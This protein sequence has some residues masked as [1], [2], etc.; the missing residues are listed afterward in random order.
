MPAARI[1]PKPL[2]NVPIDD[3]IALL[4]HPEQ[5]P[6][7][8][9]P[10]D[11]ASMVAFDPRADAPTLVH[12]WWLAE[13]AWMSYSHSTAQVQQVYSSRT[14]LSAS[15]EGTGGTDWTIAASDEFAIVA[16]RGTQPDQWEDIFSDV[17]WQPVKWD[18]GRVHLGFAEAFER[19]WPALRDRLSTLRP[20]CRVWFT[21][22]SLGAAIATLAAF[23]AT[24]AQGVVTFG[25]PLVGD[26][27][28]AG[29]F[30]ARFGARSLGYA[31]DHDLVTRVPPEEFGFPGRYTHVDRL[32]WIDPDGNIGGAPPSLARFF[33]ATIGNPVFLL[34]LMNNMETLGF[35]ALPDGLRDHTPLHYVIRVWND[36]VAHTVP[37]I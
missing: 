33:S 31:N 30:N 1:E 34:H 13:A 16:F 9:V 36:L 10:F 12:V 4:I 15:L 20:G 24:A 11:A 19:V 26:Q 35:P 21:G 27:V 3:Q 5:N 22:H 17:R 32:R 18:A 6:T 8:Y 14:G 28:F 7:A 25:S 29:T 2:P 37:E 23:R